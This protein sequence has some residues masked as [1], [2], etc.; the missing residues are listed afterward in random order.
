MHLVRQSVYR[1]L[2]DKGIDNLYHA[3]SVL[4]AC[5]FLKRGS[6][7]S[8]GTVERYGYK[9]TSQR[10][11][12]K[13]KTYSLWYDVFVD[14]A[15]IHHRARI[16]NTYGPVLFVLSTDILTDNVGRIWVTK[17]NPINW[18][19]KVPENKRWFQTIDDLDDNLTEGTFEQMVV[20]RH[21]GGE[22]PF[23]GHLEKIIVDDPCHTMPPGKADMYSMAVG[24]LMLAMNESGLSIPIERRQCRSAC[25]CDS[26]YEGNSDRLIKM[27]SPAY[28]DSK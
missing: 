16:A 12:S 5:Q 13:D 4:T 2:I 19:N 7:L 23:N 27:F 8:R 10:S 26:Y 6:L 1:T 3:N 21:C 15:D 9:Q 11:D 18:T 25:Q 17:S 20:F 22:I 28:R 14:T 24:A